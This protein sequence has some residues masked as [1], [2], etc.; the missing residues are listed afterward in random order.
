MPDQE[1]NLKKGMGIVFY[2]KLV[3]G[4]GYLK[5]QLYVRSMSLYESLA[6]ISG[7]R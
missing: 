6:G 3:L 5:I 1:T 4:Q 7:T 2:N